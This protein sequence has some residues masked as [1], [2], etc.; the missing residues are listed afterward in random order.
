MTRKRKKPPKTRARKAARTPEVKPSD[1]NRHVGVPRTP[2]YQNPP[3]GLVAPPP[4]APIEAIRQDFASHLQA[5]MLRK[6]WNQSELARQAGLHMPSGKMG[7]DVV[8]GY[9]RGRNLPGPPHRKAICAAL[10]ISSEDLG[11]TILPTATGA[12]APPLLVTS[13][14]DGYSWVRINMTLPA[15]VGLR[16]Q[17]LV[18]NARPKN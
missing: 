18:E 5:H 1:S 13:A 2:A 7:R 4:W 6:G 3:P 8:S 12:N 9:L 15:D 17:Q 10:G 16:I 14:G 11:H